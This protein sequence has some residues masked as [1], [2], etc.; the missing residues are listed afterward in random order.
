MYTRPF[1]N[2]TF[3]LISDLIW[4]VAESATLQRGKKQKWVIIGEVVQTILMVL[5]S[6][7]KV[8]HDRSSE[9]VF[10]VEEDDL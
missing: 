9:Y 8:D 7:R 1:L 10:C 5:L 4:S 3:R 6:Y 2:S